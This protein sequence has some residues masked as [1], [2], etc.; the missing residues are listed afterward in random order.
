MAAVL[1]VM[2]AVMV[3]VVL[4]VERL[5]TSETAHNCHRFVILV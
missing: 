1:A 5:P 3:A 4:A 2:L